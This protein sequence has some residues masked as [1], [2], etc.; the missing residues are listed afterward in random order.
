MDELVL[1]VHQARPTVD[2][3]SNA[4]T[5]RRQ[6]QRVRLRS[7]RPAAIYLAVHRFADVVYYRRLDHEEY[8][9]LSALQR[10]NT[11]ADAIEQAFRCR[12]TFARRAGRKDSKLLR[13]RRR[14]SLVLPFVIRTAPRSLGAP[15]LA[16]FLRDVGLPRHSTLSFAVDPHLAKNERDVGRPSFV[17]RDAI[18]TG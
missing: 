18:E 12:H 7:I 11:L 14:V 4:V 15:H 13:P 17:A 8:L 3:M 1:A 16:R 10:R 9:L 2:I 6:P 5:E